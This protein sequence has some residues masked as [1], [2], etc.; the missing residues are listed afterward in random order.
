MLHGVRTRW[1]LRSRKTAK[2]RSL[3]DTQHYSLTSAEWLLNEP[4]L[5]HAYS[6]NVAF[7]VERLC[8]RPSGHLFQRMGTHGDG[9]YVLPVDVLKQQPVLSIGVG[10]EMSVDLELAERGH[11]VFQF[12]HTIERPPATIPMITWRQL[13]LSSGEQRINEIPLREM[14][15]LSGLS[16]RTD[17]ILLMDCEGA[18][19]SCLT[20]STTPLDL[21]SV[22]SVEL[23]GLSR[24]LSPSRGEARRQAIGALTKNH[25]VVDS[26]GNNYGSGIWVGE[27]FV[28]DVLE[29]TLVHRDFFVAG[30]DH[31]PENL[32]SPNNPLLPE[33][34]LALR[35]ANSTS[36]RKADEAGLVIWSMQ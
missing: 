17:L 3:R 22:L 2:G 31:S 34:P 10:A 35:P 6:L 29:V 19:W 26:H 7:L 32:H 33:L 27:T 21:F 20:D 25:V 1:P 14:L 24:A 8:P 12:D 36:T 30:T 18:E 15:D 4:D 16:G 28:P 11:K 9:G 23:H 5:L 13:G